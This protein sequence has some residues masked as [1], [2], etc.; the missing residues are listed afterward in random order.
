MVS[1]HT[2]K[3]LDRDGII[4]ALQRHKHVIVIEEHVPQGGLAPQTKQ[5]AWDIKAACRLDTF[6]L[7]DEF[8]HNYGSHDD[9]LAAH[10]LSLAQISQR[11]GSARPTPMSQP[12]GATR[13]WRSMAGEPV[14]SDRMPPRLALG[15]DELRMIQEVH[16]LLS[17]APDRSRLSGAVREA[18]YRRLRRP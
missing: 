12:T 9:L 1:G 5:I 3:P 13:L 17:R 10:G 8:I 7:Q 16:R 2:V 14:R 4:A 11:I 6:T 18:L 15:E